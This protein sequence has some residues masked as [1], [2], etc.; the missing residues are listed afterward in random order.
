MYLNFLNFLVND[1]IFLLDE[2]FNMISELKK[3]EAEM[4]NTVEWEQRPQ[5]ERQERTRHFHQQEQVCLII[6]ILCLFWIGMLNN[7]LFA[8]Q[9]FCSMYV[10]IWKQ[11]CFNSWIYLIPNIGFCDVISMFGG[12][13]PWQMRMWG[14]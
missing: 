14:C 9:C 11:F 5:Q 2:S 1:S 10:F 13:W 6:E 12:T 4:K 8:E 3:M 7:F